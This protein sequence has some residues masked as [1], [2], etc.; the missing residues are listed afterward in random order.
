MSGL[1]ETQIISPTIEKAAAYSIIHDN[2]RGI[3]FALCSITSITM[4]DIV[5]DLDLQKFSIHSIGIYYPTFVCP[6]RQPPDVPSGITGTTPPQIFLTP[7]ISDDIISTV[8]KPI[9]KK[10]RTVETGPKGNKTQEE[11]EAITNDFS[12]MNT[13]ILPPVTTYESG[14]LIVNNDSTLSGVVN[15]AM[16]NDDPI[17]DGLKFGAED[18]KLSRAEA[19]LRAYLPL[20]IKIFYNNRSLEKHDI[21]HSALLGDPTATFVLTTPAIQGHLKEFINRTMKYF[22]AETNVPDLPK[23]TDSYEEMIKK[24]TVLELVS[25]YPFTTTVNFARELSCLPPDI[26]YKNVKAALGSKN[27]RV[28]RNAVYYLGIMGTKE[29][30]DDLFELLKT[31]KDPVE[32]ARALFFLTQRQDP[33]LVAYIIDRLQSEK[34]HIFALAMVR[35]LDK[36]SAKAAFTTL[37]EKLERTERD[38]EDYFTLLKACVKCMDTSNTDTM[39]R[40]TRTVKKIDKEYTSWLRDPKPVETFIDYEASLWP[41]LMEQLL[42]I[43]LASLNEESKRQKLES[44]LSEITRHLAESK[45][46][47]ASYSKDLKVLYFDDLVRGFLIEILPMFKTGKPYLERLLSSGYECDAFLL[48]A[49][50]TYYNNYPDEFPALAAKILQNEHMPPAMLCKTI[51]Y[52]HAANAYTDDCVKAIE[53]IIGRYKPDIDADNRDAIATAIYYLGIDQKLNPDKLRQIA[54]AEAAKSAERVVVSD[55]GVGSGDFHVH[56]PS[57][58]LR[59]SIEL[60]G[61]YNTKEAEKQLIALCSNA[62]EDVR[63]Y[64]AKALG[65]FKSDEAK[66]ILIKLLADR[67]GWVRLYSYNSLVRITG[68]EHDADWLFSKPQDLL[69]DI[70]IYTG[71]IGNGS[72]KPKRF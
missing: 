29:S 30:V 17:S 40:F 58:I 14:L 61:I 35:S 53:A 54:D 66:T 44:K 37:V 52:V 43:V 4:T 33:R 71:K 38:F 49:L 56:P 46:R 23:K 57:D 15:E 65:R 55:V 19:Y 47:P 6:T 39:A 70:K 21:F 41:R 13:Q 32:R 69:D 11:S 28:R 9:K 8:F 67:S 68:A 26:V 63:M 12:I 1:Y 36:L 3:A 2:M 10:P 48:K 34:D 22:T 24:L 62:K 59:I 18:I 60:L 20:F 50:A 72:D 31:T 27:K 25:Y 45:K 7:G 42:S 64:A 16:M 51:E 5:S